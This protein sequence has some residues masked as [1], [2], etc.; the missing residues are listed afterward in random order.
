MVSMSEDA[1]L[2]AVA[3]YYYL[4]IDQLMYHLKRRSLRYTQVQLKRLKDA[5]YL[6]RIHRHS[7]HRGKLTP[8]YTYTLKTKRYLEEQD[9]LVPPPRVPQPYFLSHTLALNDV[10]IAAEELAE[11]CPDYVRLIRAVHEQELKRWNLPHVIPDGFLHF[12]LLTTA[13]WHNFPLLVEL[14]MGTQ[15]REAWQNKVARYTRFFAESLH[16]YFHMPPEALATVA[17]IT[18]AGDERVENLQRWTEQALT[19]LG[20]REDLGD[21]FFFGD[22]FPDSG[23]WLYIYRAFR[24]AFHGAYYYALFEELRVLFEKLHAVLPEEVPEDVREFLE[25]EEDEEDDEET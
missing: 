23:W 10:L 1:I 6:E 21:F 19:R 3:S 14:D 2:K 15:N 22:V 24:I 17:V 18:T 13:G 11:V 9:I 4:D 5:G 12:Q 25:Q 20:K 7:T 8:A 16:T